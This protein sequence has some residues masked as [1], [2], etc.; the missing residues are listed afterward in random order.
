MAPVL[1]ERQLLGHGVKVTARKPPPIL[2]RPHEQPP[3]RDMYDPRHRREIIPDA[4]LVRF[5]VEDNS[6]RKHIVL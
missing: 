2:S 3:H 5:I 6:Q 4:V 1:S